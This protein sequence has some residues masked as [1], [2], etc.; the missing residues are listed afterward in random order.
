MTTS[1]RFCVNHSF[2]DCSIAG[3]IELYDDDAEPWSVNKLSCLGVGY[4][5][6]EFSP[7]CSRI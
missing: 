1:M 6:G 5:P 3:F 2:S 7:M 4:T